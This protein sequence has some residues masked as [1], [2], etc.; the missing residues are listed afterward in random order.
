MATG[1]ETTTGTPAGTEA[2]QRKKT[3]GG[4]KAAIVVALIAGFFG[5]IIGSAFPFTKFDQQQPVAQNAKA[6]AVQ[7]QASSAKQLAAKC[8]VQAA[9]ST[10]RKEG[11]GNYAISVSEDGGAVSINID[12][13]SRST[14]TSSSRHVSKDDKEFDDDPFFRDDD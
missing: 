12:G 13:K 10:A 8:P 4:S 11:P 7:P 14:K 9:I 3:G 1:D 6:A 2:V 5:Y